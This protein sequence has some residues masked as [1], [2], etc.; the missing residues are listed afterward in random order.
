MRTAITVVV[1]LLAPS[2]GS[3][4]PAPAR[5]ARAL[6]ADDCARA[7]QAGQTCVLDLPAEVLTGEHASADQ[8]AL[9]ALIFGLEASLIHVR[10]DFVPEI[11]KTAED[12]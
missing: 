3:A 5:D 6:V 10:A 4:D 1:C 2:L 9:R 11:V 12:L 7:R 8:L